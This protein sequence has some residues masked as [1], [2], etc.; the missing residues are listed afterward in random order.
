MGIRNY[1]VLFFFFMVLISCSNLI[2]PDDSLGSLM[3]V[4]KIPTS[5]TGLNKPVS[6]LKRVYCIFRKGDRRVKKFRL[7]K[8]GNEFKG[9]IKD[10]KEGSNYSITLHGFSYAEKVVA[11]AY[12]SDIKIRANKAT[13][14]YLQWQLFIPNPISP[15]HDTVVDNTPYLFTWK[16]LPDAELYEMKVDDDP[17]IRTPLIEQMLVDTSYIHKGSLD[18]GTYYWKVIAKGETGAWGLW[19]EVRIFHVNGL[20]TEPVL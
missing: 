6:E 2:G 18:Q 3:I 8:E 5:S 16:A 4:F 10:L 13:S 20:E 15:A 1:G 14:V 7:A 9:E 11:Y 17:D 19:S 12:E